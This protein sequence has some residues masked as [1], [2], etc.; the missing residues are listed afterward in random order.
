MVRVFL[1]KSQHSVDD[2]VRS[3][4]TAAE[5]VLAQFK[6][7]VLMFTTAGPRC[8]MRATDEHC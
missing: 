2:G 3:R 1:L 4:A 8:G 7:L 6:A 5:S